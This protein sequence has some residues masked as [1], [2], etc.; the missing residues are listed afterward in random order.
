MTRTRLY[1]CRMSRLPSAVGLCDSDIRG[2]ASIV[3]ASQRRLLYCKEA[4]EE[5]WIGT[6]AEVR[7]NVSRSA[8]SVTFDREIARLELVDLCDQ[9]IDVN[10]AFVEYLRFGNGRMPKQFRNCHSRCFTPAVYTRDNVPIRTEFAATPQFI[11]AYPTDPADN[12]KRVLM[13]GADSNGLTIYSQDGLNRVI[14]QFANLSTPFVAWPMQFS[15]IT[16]IQ[17]DV[18]NAPVN[19][20]MVDP[21]TG[22]QTLLTSM[23]PSE[24]TAWY[25]RYIFTDLPFS[26]CAPNGSVVGSTV[27]VTAIVKLEL[28]PVVGDTDYCLI[29]NIEALTE[30]AMAIRYSTMDSVDSKQLAAIKHRDAVRFLNGELTH[31]LGKDDP[32]TYI[33]LFGSARLERRGIGTMI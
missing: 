28:V 17:K 16:G 6:W 19:I 15:S 27:S 30:E 24:T 29:G 31:Y 26:C 20:F 12:G 11:W 22:A 8:P 21:T 33:A 13:Q 25:R 18:T 7:F 10:N 23:Q 32:A 4:G 14:G 9:P 3:N 5:S 2:I 1:D